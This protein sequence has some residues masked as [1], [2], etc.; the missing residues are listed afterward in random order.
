[1]IVRRLFMSTMIRPSTA[2]GGAARIAAKLGAA[3]LGG[4][5]KPHDLVPGGDELCQS[6]TNTGARTGDDD[7]LFTHVTILL[8]A[9]HGLR[10]RQGS[11]RP[12]I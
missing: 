7:N 10:D 6:L 12:L 11:I 3:I 2:V 4:T 9:D 8:R 5:Y 1:M